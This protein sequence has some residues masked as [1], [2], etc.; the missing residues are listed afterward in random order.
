M[1]MNKLFLMDK[2]KN[3]FLIKSIYFTKIIIKSIDLNGS[4][5]IWT[6]L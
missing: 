6:R 2:F 3:K 1:V 5:R 4:K